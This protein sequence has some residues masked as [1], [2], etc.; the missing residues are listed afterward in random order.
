M[1]YVEERRW[2]LLGRGSAVLRPGTAE[3]LTR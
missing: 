2:V 1:E 3:T